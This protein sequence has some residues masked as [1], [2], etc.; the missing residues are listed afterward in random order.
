[1]PALR[2]WVTHKGSQAY[3]HGFIQ[4]LAH[5]PKAAVLAIVE[6]AGLPTG[7]RA[8]SDA[9]MDVKLLTARLRVGP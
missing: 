8:G 9:P 5:D 1:V 7:A 3:H 2:R 6:E 4:G